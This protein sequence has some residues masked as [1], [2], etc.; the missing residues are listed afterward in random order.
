[1]SWR[2]RGVGVV[3]AVGAGVVGAK[4]RGAVDTE[5]EKCCQCVL[6]PLSLASFVV[7]ALVLL[8][9]WVWVLLLGSASGPP[10][11]LA[12]VT[13]WV[14]VVRASWEWGV[15]VAWSL[16]L[17]AFTFG[18]FLGKGWEGG[19][20]WPLLGLILLLLLWLLVVG[21][22]VRFLPGDLH[23]RGGGGELLPNGLVAALLVLLGAGLVC[24][25]AFAVPVV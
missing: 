4:Q 21:P 22:R 11:A 15:G 3:G 25:R 8:L 13:I 9:L 2:E 16:L 1:M 23:F 17:L 6:G 18:L 5:E 14:V 12:C 10:L 7:C 19:G 24:L 20:C